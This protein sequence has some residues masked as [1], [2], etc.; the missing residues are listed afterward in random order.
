MR[1]LAR[2][3]RRAEE[4]PEEFARETIAEAPAPFRARLAKPRRAQLAR[5]LEAFAAFG[6]EPRAAGLALGAALRG[7]SRLV[8][9]LAFVRRTFPFLK[10]LEP[11]RLLQAWDWPL[12]LPD[13]RRQ[14][15]FYRLGVLPGRSA[16]AGGM[17]LACEAAERIHRLTG[18]DARALDLIVGVF[19]GAA[20]GYPPALAR[21]AP[22]PRCED[23]PAAAQCQYCKYRPPAG[24]SAR[25]ST[26]KDWDP[27]QR[28]RERLAENGAAQLSDAELMAILLRTGTARE[29]ALEVAQR[30]L[31]ELGGLNGLD[32]AALGELRAKPGIG[33][34]K[35]VTIKAAIELGKR[36][37]SAVG[38]DGQGIRC[39]RDL[40]NRFQHRFINAKQEQFHQVCLNTKHV[41]IAESLVTQGTLAS[42]VVH[43]R[44]AFRD[45]IR[46]SAAAVA[47]V[48]NHPSG[49]P[50]PSPRDIEFTER[51]EESARILGI[52]MLDHIIIGAG[53]YYSFRDRSEFDARAAPDR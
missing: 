16:T 51:L 33:M 6:P 40:Y 38:R 28:P 50:A 43:P 10:G 34:V 3:V 2:A 36:L 1:E 31:G 46:N 12:V 44:E 39:A 7:A 23:C 22:R 14:T 21:C 42:S 20:P 19:A 41:V 26:I 49:D 13:G 32:E 52:P 47:F 18:E 35:A 27:R 25:R 29:T 5:A 17:R 53:R 24:E 48:H 30:A 8:D 11:Y 45:A 9:A 4:A 37:A 15:L